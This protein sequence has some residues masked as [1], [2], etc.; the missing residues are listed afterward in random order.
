M[1]KGK[2]S[3]EYC[4]AAT[5]GCVEGLK[6]VGVP[7]VDIILAL[8]RAILKLQHAEWCKGRVNNV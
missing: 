7:Q 5:D 3:D 8:N 1:S 4:D 2:V 6:N